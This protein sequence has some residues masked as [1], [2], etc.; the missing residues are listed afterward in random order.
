M[1]DVEQCAPSRV[2]YSR[3]P[4]SPCEGGPVDFDSIRQAG[5]GPMPKEP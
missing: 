4:I 2:W 1:G 3:I 5:S